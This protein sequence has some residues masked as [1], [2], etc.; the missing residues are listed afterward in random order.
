[1]RFSDIIGQK[2]IKDHFIN[3]VRKDRI[4]HAY[5]LNG[6]DGMG[7][8]ALAEAFSS[9]LLC[10]DRKENDSCNECTSCKKIE[11]GNHLDIIYVT[12]EKTIISVDDIRQQINDNI[13]IKPYE[14]EK[15]IYIVDEAELMKA[16]AQNAL[17]K[18]IEN[19]PEYAII[20]L[21][22]NNADTFLPT[23]LSRCVRLN[24]KPLPEKVIGNYMMKKYEIA[25]YMAKVYAA[26]S[27]GNIG[28][29][30]KAY[31]MAH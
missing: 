19:P 13:D 24:L 3:A 15:K 6:E 7:K 12:H 16:E 18:T 28:A 5:I 20:L 11:H 27:Q 31:G 17:L 29:A 8:M 30:E 2:E 23:I 25:D 1:M 26:F 14:S 9:Y 21:L 22:T 10:K 4:S